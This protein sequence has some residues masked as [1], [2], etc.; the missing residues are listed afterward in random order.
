MEFWATSCGNCEQLEPTMKAK[1]A[2]HGDSVAVIGVAVPVN[3]TPGRVKAYVEK[4]GLGW[5]QLFDRKGNASGAYDAPATSYVVMLDAAGKGRVY[6]ARREAG[7]RVRDQGAGASCRP[8]L[9]STDS[10]WWRAGAATCIDIVASTQ[11]DSGIPNRASQLR[12]VPLQ[13]Q[14]QR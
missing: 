1:H 10:L 12:V 5:I 7:P 4:H 3:Q 8:T 14:L 6:G 2:K 13:R 9:K 11:G